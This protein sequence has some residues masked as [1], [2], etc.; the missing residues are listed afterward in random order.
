MLDIKNMAW[1]VDE[2]ALENGMLDYK[3]NNVFRPSGLL[4]LKKFKV[5]ELLVISRAIRMYLP[6]V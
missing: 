5:A 2:K 4:V 6:G 3:S 1:K